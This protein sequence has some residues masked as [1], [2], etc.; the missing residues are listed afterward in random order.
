MT[1]RQ[2]AERDI[3]KDELESNTM[4]NLS[5]VFCPKSPLAPLLTA[6]RDRFIEELE[7]AELPPGFSP[8]LATGPRREAVSRRNAE[9]LI[10]NLLEMMRRRDPTLSVSLNEATYRST[11]LSRGYIN[12]IKLAAHESRGLLILK[13][14]FR[15]HTDQTHSRTARI[16]LTRRFAALLETAIVSEDDLV[17][18]P[19]DLIN[20]RRSKKRELV[21]RGK[22]TRTVSDEQAEVLRAVEMSLAWFNL[23]LQEYDITYTGAGGGVTRHLFPVLYAVYTNTF[24]QGG[25]FYTGKGGHQG[26]SE[27]ERMTIRFNGHPTIELDYGGLHPRMLYHMAGDDYPLNEDPYAKVLDALGMD[28]TGVFGEF[29]GIR[30]DLKEMLL[31]LVN[32]RGTKRQTANRAEWRLFRNWMDLRAGEAKDERRRQC[33]ERESTWATAGLTVAGVLDAFHD[34]HHPISNH[35]STGCGLSLQNLDATI[36]RWVLFEMMVSNA[37]ECVPVLPIHDSFI[38]FTEYADRLRDAMR[39]I[40]SGVMQ[41]HTGSGKDFEIPIK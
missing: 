9:T 23:V 36:A 5:L 7:R 12:L 14:G 39:A 28:G 11:K 8:P 33:S 37:D 3:P 21:P 17:S 34:A 29:P 2:T 41:Q 22:W 13:E 4:S 38:T 1:A 24:D 6:L 35:F 40:Y 15:N 31:A 16:K 30:G 10:A 32:G 18:E 26:Q 25:R 20:L 27:A 19:H